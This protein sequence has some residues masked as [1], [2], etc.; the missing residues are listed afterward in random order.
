MGLIGLGLQR[1]PLFQVDGAL[2]QQV[3]G[4]PQQF[5]VMGVG[6]L[7][8]VGLVFEQALS[9]IKVRRFQVFTHGGL[10]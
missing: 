9:R 4:H 7:L 10:R 2:P 1:L 8:P 3:V 6:G 5:G